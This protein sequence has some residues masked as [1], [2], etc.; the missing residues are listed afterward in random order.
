MTDKEWIDDF[1]KALEQ[2]KEPAPEFTPPPAKEATNP[3]APYTPPDWVLDR[4]I[5]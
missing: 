3:F 5:A 4:R 2:R 1:H